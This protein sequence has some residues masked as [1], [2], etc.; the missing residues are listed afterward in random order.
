MKVSDAATV[1]PGRSSDRF[2]GRVADTR[3][4]AE[5]L[6]VRPHGSTVSRQAPGPDTVPARTEVTPRGTTMENAPSDAPVVE[7]L[8]TANV[9]VVTAPGRAEPPGT[10]ST[11]V[12]TVTGCVVRAEAAGGTRATAP[13][14]ANAA[15]PAALART[16]RRAWVMDGTGPP[17]VICP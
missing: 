16:S 8:V 6:A 2:S 17:R 1:A 9:A 13:V 11:L 14:S 3:T 15:T 12:T 7:P 5:Q 10:P 4:I